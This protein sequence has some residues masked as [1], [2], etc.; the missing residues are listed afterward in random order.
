MAG[1]PRHKNFEDFQ[2]RARQAILE[3][4]RSIALGMRPEL[5]AS[6]ALAELDMA[7]NDTL[8]R[9]ARTL[10]ERCDVRIA[11]ALQLAIAHFQR[12][13]VIQ[14]MGSEGAEV[15]RQEFL[16]ILFDWTDSN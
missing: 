2:V 5:A 10:P 1:K 3:M 12:D 7:K 4:A 9:K 6:F 15:M 11:Q 14:V 8:P 13:D 16:Q